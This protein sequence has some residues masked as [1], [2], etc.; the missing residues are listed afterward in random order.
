MV[1]FS[2][3]A[4][5]AGAA[6]L[7]LAPAAR[8]AVPSALSTHPGFR[9]WTRPARASGLPLLDPVMTDRGQKRMLDWLDRRPAVVAF[10]ASWCGPC[11]AEKAHQAALARRLTAAGAATRIVAL[12][13][14]DDVDLAHG[15]NLLDRLGARGLPLAQAMPVTET[16]FRR[17]FAGN[18]GGARDEIALPVVMLLDGDGLELGRAV[19]EMTGPD[20]RSDYWQ[21]EATFDFLSRLL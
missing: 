7:T 2:R 21:D 17:Q 8:A 19:G 3:R 5:L 16:H 18:S 9:A 12:Q 15:Q 11:L 6:A 13:I 4:A 1:K 14:F 20:G 10:W